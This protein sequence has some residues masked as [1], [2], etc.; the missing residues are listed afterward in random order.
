[1]YSLIIYLNKNG[2]IMKY[3][4]VISLIALSGCKSTIVSGATEGL[5]LAGRVSAVPSNGG[6]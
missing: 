4:L 1:M 2:V 5:S 3:F 6:N